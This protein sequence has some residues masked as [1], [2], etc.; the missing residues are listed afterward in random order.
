MAANVLS[1][2]AR[3]ASRMGHAIS[4]EGMPTIPGLRYTLT[5][6]G[7]SVPRQCRLHRRYLQ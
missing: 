4:Y 7:Q 3:T 2:A 6:N 1:A 5:G